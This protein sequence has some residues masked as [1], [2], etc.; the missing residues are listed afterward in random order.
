MSHH[1]LRNRNLEIILPVMDLE[2]QAHEIG[3]DGRGAG[4][5]LDRGDPLAGFG[6]YNGE[7]AWFGSAVFSGELPR[8]WVAP[9][10]R[11]WGLNDSLAGKKRK[12]QEDGV[13][14]QTE[15][16]QSA[17]VGNM[18]MWIDVATDDV[19]GHPM[20]PRKLEKWNHVRAGFLA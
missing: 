7:T 6:A 1:F 12:R 17:R 3:Q 9:T 10:A 8:E 16:A 2:L 19:F 20:R 5:R 13:P 15:R 11:Y 14:F 18:A 4:L